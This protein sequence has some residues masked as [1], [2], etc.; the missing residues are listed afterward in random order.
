ASR[1]TTAQPPGGSTT[2]IDNPTA[3]N[4]TNVDADDQNDSAQGEQDAGTTD[5]NSAD[6][7]PG[8]GVIA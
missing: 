5:D 7:P 2:T 6:M 1:F 3:D 8:T 4:T